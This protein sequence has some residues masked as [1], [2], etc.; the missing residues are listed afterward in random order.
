ME[1]KQAILLAAVSAAAIAGLGFLVSEDNKRKAIVRADNLAQAEDC[2]KNEG[3]CN[4]A[5]KLAWL[6]DDIKGDVSK[7]VKEAKYR[8]ELISKAKACILEKS[9]YSCDGI[10]K[11]E[12][13][14]ISPDLAKDLNNAIWSA[15]QKVAERERKEQQRLARIRKEKE[16]F[17]RMGWWEQQTGIFVRWCT[18]TC[19]RAGLIGDGSYSLMEVWCRDRACGDIYA[20]VNFIRNGSVV[21]WTNDTLYL[22]YGQKGVLTFQ[23]YGLRGGNSTQLVKFSARG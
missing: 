7:A 9:I 13:A 5:I 20:Q 17:D 22:G 14:S 4:S 21:G 18:D 6:P 12:V 16:E 23:K 2:L 1:R 15:K 3:A 8:R 11:Q 19:S 10:D